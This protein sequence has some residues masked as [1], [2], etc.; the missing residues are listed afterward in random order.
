MSAGKLKAALG[1]RYCIIGDSQSGRSRLLRHIAVGYSRARYIATDFINSVKVA[2]NSRILL[3]N[4]PERELDAAGRTELSRL[5]CAFTGTVFFV[6]NDID[7]IN[8]TAT[9]ITDVTGNTLEGGW[10]NFVSFSISSKILLRDKTKMMPVAAFPRRDYPAIAV[11]T[12]VLG[13]IVAIADGTKV[14]FTGP[15]AAEALAELYLKLAALPPAN[16][17]AG[18]Y[19]HYYDESGPLPAREYFTTLRI[20]GR[21]PLLT[22]PESA[23]LGLAAA[24][25]RDLPLLDNPTRYLSVPQIFGLIEHFRD[26]TVV[27]TSDDSAFIRMVRPGVKIEFV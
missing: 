3:V 5:L 14:L 7:F 17:T 15:R 8:S 23:R 19:N 22:A 6:T 21:F 18:Y 26:R 24:L 4:K 12:P 13:R 16:T 9:S 2:A 25:S 11:A 10:G 27:F 20:R 1:G